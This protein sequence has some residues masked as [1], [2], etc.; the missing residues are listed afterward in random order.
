MIDLTNYPEYQHA[1]LSRVFNKQIIPDD[2][3]EDT[4]ALISTAGSTAL[5]QSSAKYKT[6]IQ[7]KNRQKFLLELMTEHQKNCPDTPIETVYP[8]IQ[9]HT[10][11]C[12]ASLLD[13]YNT[14]NHTTDTEAH[15]IK[16]WR[17]YQTE[18]PLKTLYL[19]WGITP[20]EPHAKDEVSLLL[21]DIQNKSRRATTIQR[22]KNAMAQ[23][24]QK[25]WFMV[26]DTI[27]LA[28][29]KVE[30]FYAD[31]HA[32]NQYTRKIG[33]LI[34]EATGRKQN[35][36]ITDVYQYFC[37]PEFGDENGRLHFHLIHLM[38]K[39]PRGSYDPNIGRNIQTNRCVDSL[40]SLWPYGT[41]LPCA[42]RY[43]HDAY[44]KQLGWA[45]PKVRTPNGQITP[46]AI[47]PM[48]AI[49]NY[50]A[51]YVNKQQDLKLKHSK[52]RND[53]SWKQQV[54]TMSGSI[55]NFEQDFRV[56]MSRN[57]GMTLPS[58]EHL[59]VSDLTELTNLHHT[60][61]PLH[62]LVKLK[63]KIEICKRLAI[64]T[65][66]N[67]LELTPLQ[68][69]LLANLRNSIKPQHQ[70]NL[71]NSTDTETTT[72]THTD[73]SNESEKYLQSLSCPPITEIRL[74]SY[75]GTK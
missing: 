17:K 57:F 60:T 19:M 39:L 73:I 32:I 23:A 62:K 48:D 59:S 18:C 3:I 35:D 69:N 22:I 27:T 46:Q 44:G 49:C 14:I 72:L 8:S 40:R 70:Y 5:Q 10:Q 37:V 45:W 12:S 13:I 20:Q 36:S 38:A 61:S 41:N 54:K 7:I 64:L 1:T 56:R 29:D 34:N 63:S 43:H 65:I 28:P 16:L 9:L 75:G 74:S 11:M 71:L 24:H 52:L 31:R 26:F 33:R 15:K 50:V 66:D 68:P 30:A 55:K 4:T 25:G 58:M 67:L 6:I 51:K 2:L 53:E 42:A 21:L 47:K